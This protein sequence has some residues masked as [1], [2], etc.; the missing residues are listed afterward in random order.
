MKSD[1]DPSGNSTQPCDLR[2]SG[3]EADA[4]VV[5]KVTELLKAKG[6]IA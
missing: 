1:I 6:V 3:N 4:A 5:A 2:I